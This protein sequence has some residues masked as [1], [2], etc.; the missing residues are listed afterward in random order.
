MCV[1][2]TSCAAA[3][4]ARMTNVYIVCI[5]M[6]SKKRLKRSDDPSNNHAKPVNGG[7]I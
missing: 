2:A 7:D 6:K 4:D 3:A 5:A 1:C